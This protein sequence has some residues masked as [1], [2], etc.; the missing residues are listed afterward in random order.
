MALCG[1]PAQ[2]L[3][4]ARHFRP[5]RSSSGLADQLVVLGVRS[6]P[7][8]D[9][10]VRCF[11]AHRAIVDANARRVET[12]HLLEVKRGVPGIAFELFETAVGKT[13]DCNW[14]RAIAL[15]E[16]RRGLVIQSFVVWPVAWAF[17]A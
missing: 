7:E 11:H 1:G 8:P 6:D 10:A 4:H 13:L 15:P 2:A 16:L 17:N 14:R 5:V 9:D 3:D 12:P